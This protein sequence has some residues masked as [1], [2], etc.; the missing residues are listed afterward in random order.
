MLHSKV[1]QFLFFKIQKFYDFFLKIQK[2]Y[3]F[4]S[5]FT[6]SW[7]HS[8]GTWACS[9]F[10]YF[11][12]R[13]V[14][15]RLQTI[16]NFVNFVFIVHWFDWNAFFPYEVVKLHESLQNI[17]TI[18]MSKTFASPE[19]SCELCDAIVKCVFANSHCWQLCKDNIDIFADVFSTCVQPFFAHKS[20]R[21]ETDLDTIHKLVNFGGIFLCWI[22]S[23]KVP[24]LWVLACFWLHNRK[25][26]AT[27]GARVR[28]TESSKIHNYCEFGED[29][30]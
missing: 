11:K 13:Y 1:L 19:F 28:G 14:R 4:S 27:N 24:K 12:I 7:F 30:F 26:K 25:W 8:F 15:T 10:A 6:I 3:V 23:P 16:H 21:R 18:Y 2:F 20:Q 17:H 9:R 22:G 5:K 29:A